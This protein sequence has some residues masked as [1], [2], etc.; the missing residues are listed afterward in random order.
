MWF[1][2]ENAGRILE[3]LSLCHRRPPF[4][5]PYLKCT[6]AMQ[7]HQFVCDTI[8]TTDTLS[9]GG[10]GGCA[11]GLTVIEDKQSKT[12]TS[13]AEKLSPY[14]DHRK[15]PQ[16]MNSKPSN[17]PPHRPSSDHHSFWWC[18][19]LLSL[20]WPSPSPSASSLSA[21]LQHHL[22]I[23]MSYFLRK[24]LHL[25]THPYLLLTYLTFA[26]YWPSLFG[27]LVFDDQPGKLD[28]C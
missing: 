26:V 22:F 14:L 5:G 7:Q 16:Q 12:K 18:F 2:D 4:L 6:F 25:L 13:S 15:T 8:A 20:Q 27:E 17:S 23:S 11:D 1:P 28:G 10:G 21:I 19:T 24:V 3:G 9:R